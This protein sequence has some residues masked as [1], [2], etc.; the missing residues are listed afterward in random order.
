MFC[1][2]TH[3]RFA[4]LSSSLATQRLAAFLTMSGRLRLCIY[5]L[6]CCYLRLIPSVGSNP[7]EISNGTSSAYAQ[8]RSPNP[9]RNAGLQ[10]DANRERS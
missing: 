1:V 5:M 6:G 10:L 7:A 9:N 8:F 3:D 4:N 2:R